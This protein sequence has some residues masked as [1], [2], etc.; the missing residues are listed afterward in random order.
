MILIA[1]IFVPQFLGRQ[2]DFLSMFI[3]P[4]QAA[5]QSIVSPPLAGYHADGNGQPGFDHIEDG[6]RFVILPFLTEPA[7]LTGSP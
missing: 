5:I 1:L 4:I 7:D 3:R 6:A 2:F